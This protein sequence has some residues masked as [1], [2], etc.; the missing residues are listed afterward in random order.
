MKKKKIIIVFSMLLSMFHVCFISA[1]DRTSF[2]GNR[3]LPDIQRSGCQ[4]RFDDGQQGDTPVKGQNASDLSPVSASGSS[5]DLSPN[6]RSQGPTPLGVYGFPWINGSPVTQCPVTPVG[7]ASSLSGFQS[8]FWKLR[9]TVPPGADFP[10]LPAEKSP[11]RLLRCIFESRNT[12]LIDFSL[13]QGDEVC[14]SP[15]DSRGS[16]RGSIDLKFPVPARLDILDSFNF[17]NIGD[18]DNYD[19]WLFAWENGEICPVCKDGAAQ[20]DNSNNSFLY[21]CDKCEVIDRFIHSNFSWLYLGSVLGCVPGVDTY[22]LEHFIAADRLNI[23]AIFSTGS[24]IMVSSYNKRLKMLDA[25]MVVLVASKQEMDANAQN[26]DVISEQIDDLARRI[27]S[28]KEV[29]QDYCQR[30]NFYYNHKIIHGSVP[31]LLESNPSIEKINSCID[32]I[33]KFIQKAVDV[34]ADNKKVLI[35]GDGGMDTVVT[36]LACWLIVEEWTVEEAI[37]QARAGRLEHRDLPSQYR[38]LIEEF[39]QHLK[40]L[41]D[42]NAEDA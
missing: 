1:M 14:S 7:R 8:K 13:T 18:R 22:F 10:R 5:Q 39:Y 38:I 33:M 40:K 42:Q 3:P 4:V 15:V 35:V 37:I 32:K 9:P 29:V 19:S 6:P 20:R 24:S 41:A 2:G 31:I 30:H 17:E 28:F 34:E 12:P 16:R 11:C 26:V 21:R 27:T 36:L 23:G 25:E